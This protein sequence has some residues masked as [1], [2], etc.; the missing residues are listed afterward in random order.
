MHRTKRPTLAL[1]RT[2]VRVLQSAALEEVG[3][4]FRAGSVT[5]PEGCNSQKTMHCSTVKPA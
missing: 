1:D 5:I 3:G 4:G 2:T